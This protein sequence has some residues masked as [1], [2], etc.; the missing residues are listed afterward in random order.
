MKSPFASLL[1]STAA[2][3]FA[4]GAT[5][6]E[7][8]LTN[9][10]V[11]AMVKK[12]IAENPDLIMKSV[13]SY[14]MK[15]QA[16]AAVKASDSITSMQNDIVNDP[17]SP[18][19][20]NPKGDVTV[21]EFFDYHC[22]YCKHFFP[23]LTR[24]LD[25][26]KNVRVVFKEFP[27]LSEDSILAAKAALAVSKLD[28]TKYFSYH[29]ALMKSSGQ[30]TMEMLTDKA[31]ELGI[32]PDAFKKA[33]ESPDIANE[34]AHTKDLTQSLNIAG[35]PALIIGSDLTPGAIEMDV[36]KAKVA[37]ARAAASQKKS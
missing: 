35:T 6:Q 13:E 23:L 7:K 18:S 4:F 26:D 36:L 34:L 14:Q 33:M 5:A 3:C 28:K 30:F 20:G 9:A 24:L 1:I 15:Q 25:E 12:V 16:Q 32:D 19:V 2:L 17:N 22:G 10:D 31:K 11:E 8:P 29:T 21:V 37:A 27:I